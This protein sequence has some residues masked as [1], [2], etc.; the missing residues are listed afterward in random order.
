CGHKIAHGLAR[1]GFGRELPQILT[2]SD[3]ADELENILAAWRTAL[4]RELTTNSSG[5]L[6]KRHPRLADNINGDFPN[7][8]IIELYTNPLTSWS[9]SFAG[10]PPDPSLWIPRKPVV[11]EVAAFCVVHFGWQE[12]IL[13]R[14]KSNFWPGVALRMIYS[15]YL[16]Y[17]R[18]RKLLATPETNAT[19]LKIVS[20][21]N[22]KDS[23]SSVPLDLF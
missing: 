8:D 14:L 1:C 17:D 19:L 2:T 3:H 9:S 22:N 15:R 7:L 20:Q 11:H 23:Y 12:V 6:N 21:Q 10:A 13:D 16:I 5:F 4:K 18:A